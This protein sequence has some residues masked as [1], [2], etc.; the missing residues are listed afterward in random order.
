MSIS[1]SFKTF[2]SNLQISNDTVNTIQNRYYQIIK[3]VTLETCNCLYVGSYGRGTEIF[4]NDI[5]MILKL[6]YDTYLKFNSYTT[7]GQFA[8]LQEV[9]KNLEK[10]YNTSFLKGNRQVIKVNFSDGMN[11]K[12]TPAFINKDKSYTY[13]D[14]N[15]GGKW[16][17]T[18]PR[19]E[20]EAMNSMDRETNENLKRLCRMVRSWKKQNNVSISGFLIDTLSYNFISNWKYK[21]KSYKYYDLMSQDFFQYLKH[22]SESQLYC[23]APG[24]NHYIHNYMHLQ[25][26]VSEAYNKA[27]YAIKNKAKENIAKQKWREI[28]GPNFPTV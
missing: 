16:R 17:I 10:T 22:I 6:P 23:L 19:K 1:E 25:I 14:S 13:P 20:I 21:D 12:I 5:D 8:L 11:F 27:L 24:S 4:P 7:N 18:N 9:K 26:E 28:Y 3:K 2:C 15:D